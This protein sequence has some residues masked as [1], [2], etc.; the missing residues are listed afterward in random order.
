MM[1]DDP[2][3]RKRMKDKY[4]LDVRLV[5]MTTNACIFQRTNSP[6]KGTLKA[7][8]EIMIAKD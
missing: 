8:N 3:Q 4:S 7:L 5:D 1:T 2:K 6:A